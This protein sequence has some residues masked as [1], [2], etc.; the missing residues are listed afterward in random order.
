MRRA[1]IRDHVRIDVLRVVGAH[2]ARVGQQFEIQMRHQTVDRK[3]A[4]VHRPAAAA[5]SLILA[6]R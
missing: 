2:V 1:E 4:A 5:M 6:L 3:V